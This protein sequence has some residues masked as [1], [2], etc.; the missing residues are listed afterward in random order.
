[1]KPIFASMILCLCVLFGCTPTVRVEYASPELQ[2]VNNIE[3]LSFEALPRYAA[4]SDLEFEKNCGTIPENCVQFQQEFESSS[5]ERLTLN[6]KKNLINNVVPR[7]LY[8]G[9][10]VWLESGDAN[11]V[12][13]QVFKYT[14][15]HAKEILT[16]LD[17]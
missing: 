5:G 9:H 15:Q 6:Q 4:G 1:M 10:K 14:A 12:N 16:V 17:S 11:Q 7:L 3:L 2:E 13:L 8:L